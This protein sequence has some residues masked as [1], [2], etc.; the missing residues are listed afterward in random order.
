LLE[1]LLS[2]IASHAGTPAKELAGVPGGLCRPRPQSKD[3]IDFLLQ[4]EWPGWEIVTLR[5]NHD[6]AVIDF[7]EAPS[8]TR[9]A[10]LRRR[11]DAGQLWRQGAHVRRRSAFAVARDE[12]VEK[13][14]PEHMSFC[15]R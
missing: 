12:F 13:C 14:P 9:L 11:R 2:Q 1:R 4:L 15:A 6:Q 5:G 8:P 7:V 10:R 3:V